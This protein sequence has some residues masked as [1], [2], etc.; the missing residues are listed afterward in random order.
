MCGITAFI[1]SKSSGDISS[2]RKYFLELSKKIRHRGPDWNGIYMDNKVIITHERL[3]IVGIDH[4]SQP[5]ENNKMVL[6]VNGEIYNYKT[7]YND[8][9]HNKYVPTTQSDCEI[10]IN[11]YQEFGVECIK[12]LDGVFSFVLYDDINGKILVGRDPIGVNPLYYGITPNKV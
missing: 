3:S 9:L 10:I 12:M 2:K 7:L 4:G 1:A 5:I 11:L 8:V 6:S